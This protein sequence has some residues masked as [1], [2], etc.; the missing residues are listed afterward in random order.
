MNRPVLS[1][2][3]ALGMTVIA[4]SESVPRDRNMEIKSVP[5]PMPK[6]LVRAEAFDIVKDWNPPIVHLKGNA[7]VRIYSTAKAPRGVI[8]L[9]ADVV[10]LNQTTGDITPR[11][12]VRL[13]IEDIK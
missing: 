12:N 3:L 9:Q 4:P 7:K 8:V 2:A 13:T 10:D 11:G 5:V 1:L 6:G